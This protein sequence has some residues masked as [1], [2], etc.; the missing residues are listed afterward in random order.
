M[1][2]SIH[3][4]IFLTFKNTDLMLVGVNVFH[5]VQLIPVFIGFVF[6][7]SFNTVSNMEILKAI[8]DKIHDDYGDQD[9]C[10]WSKAMIEGKS[11]I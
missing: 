5:S 9:H 2:F 7:F 3:V 8:T 1:E 11:K 4:C 10:P 6:L